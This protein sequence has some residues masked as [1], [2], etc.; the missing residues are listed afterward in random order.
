[1]EINEQKPRRG[2]FEVRVGETVVTST[3]DEAR[4]FPLLKAL[5]IPHVADLVRAELEQSSTDR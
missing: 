1:V 3:L 5:D 4:P 2:I